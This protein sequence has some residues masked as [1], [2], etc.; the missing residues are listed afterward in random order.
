MA[1]W[2]NTQNMCKLTLLRCCISKFV[3]FSLLPLKVIVIYKKTIT[4][5]TALWIVGVCEVPVVKQQ[6]QTPKVKEANKQQLC[7]KKGELKL[8]RKHGKRKRGKGCFSYE[9]QCRKYFE[10]KEQKRKEKRES[11]VDSSVAGGVDVLTSMTDRGN[12]R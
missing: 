11:V 5:E 12:P 9:K 3:Y 8:R 10:S 7:K 6:Q 4:N 1:L 2:I